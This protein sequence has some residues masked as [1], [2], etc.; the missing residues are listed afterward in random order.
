MR[1][2]FTILLG[3][4]L[5]LRTPCLW[6]WRWTEVLESFVKEG[7]AVDFVCAELNVDTMNVSHKQTKTRVRRPQCWAHRCHP[8]TLCALLLF[9]ITSSLHD[10]YNGHI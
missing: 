7:K 8:D 1:L 4:M 2:L 5:Y 9:S 10:I 3:C 6:R